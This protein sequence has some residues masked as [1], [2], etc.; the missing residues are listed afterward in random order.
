VNAFSSLYHTFRAGHYPLA[1]IKS[2]RVNVMQEL[3][4]AADLGPII[5]FVT[6]IVVGLLI[7]SA[8]WLAISTVIVAGVVLRTIVKA[9][10]SKC[11]NVQKS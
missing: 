4:R 3:W 11:A 2:R 5:T 9:I 6:G 1:A 8:D 7:P 10:D